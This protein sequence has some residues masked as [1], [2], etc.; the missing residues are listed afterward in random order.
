MG[1]VGKREG[2]SGTLPVLVLVP[3]LERGQ[4]LVIPPGGD[5][6]VVVTVAV[7]EKCW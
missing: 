5:S 2:H 3:V 7:G 1:A 6:M 4:A